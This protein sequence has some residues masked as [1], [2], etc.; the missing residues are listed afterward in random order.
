MHRNY[1]RSILFWLKL[2]PLEKQNDTKQRF[3]QI[4]QLKNTPSTL[5]AFEIGRPLNETHKNNIC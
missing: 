5:D 3:E 1:L 2:F 4:I